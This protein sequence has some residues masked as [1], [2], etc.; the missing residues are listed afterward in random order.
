MSEMP[1]R[2]HAWLHPD[3]QNSGGWNLRTDCTSVHADCANYV[4]ASALE[5]AERENVELRAENERMQKLLKLKDEYIGLLAESEGELAV[6]AGLHHCG[7]PKEKLERG[8][9]L[10]AQIAELE[11]K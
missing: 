11:G 2:I 3:K 5:S 8:K 6:F 9:K 10:R 1:K 4:P 7:V